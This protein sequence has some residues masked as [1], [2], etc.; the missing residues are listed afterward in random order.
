MALRPLRPCKT[1]GCSELVKD[2]YCDTHKRLSYKQQREDRPSWVSMYKTKRWID[3]RLQY[4]INNPLCVRCGKD[5]RLTPANTVDHIVDHKG[6]Y[7]LFWDTNNWQ[8]LC[9]RCH[10]SKTATENNRRN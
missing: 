8:S 2:T 7:D 10:S 1:V 5:G 3:N 4:L 9:A 6:H